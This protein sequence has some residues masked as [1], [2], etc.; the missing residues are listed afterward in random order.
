MIVFAFL[1]VD[2][3]WI[4]WLVYRGEMVS[5]GACAERVLSIWHTRYLIKEAQSGQKIPNYKRELEI[6][7]IRSRLFPL[8]V[9]RLFGLYFFQDLESA[10]A[11]GQRWDGNFRDEH[12]A[13]IEIIGKPVISKYDSEWI[14]KHMRSKDS[15]WIS[16]Y[17]AE[18]PMGAAPL[19]ELLVEGRAKILGTRIRKLAYETVKRKWPN[20]LGLLE[21]SRV[22]ALLDSD[23]GLIWPLITI[24][25]KRAS[26]KLYLNFADA[27][28]EG[29]LERFSKFDGPKNTADLNASSEIVPP[30]LTNYFVEFTI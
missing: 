22:A 12:L 30:D 17:F 20:S 25:G 8:K 23:L 28:D 2:I 16:S 5:P 15:S 1:N 27:T 11:A 7:D 13:E 14:S 4:A 3:P 21:L 9:S 19:W 18:I 10:R 29:F 6:E 26:L 24:D